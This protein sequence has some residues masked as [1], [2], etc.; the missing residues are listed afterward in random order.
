MNSKSEAAE[1]IA[2][3]ETLMS[4]EMREYRTVL[5]QSGGISPLQL[6]PKAQDEALKEV[7]L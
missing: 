1:R 7:K 6:T 2:Q 3:A 4:D 5:L